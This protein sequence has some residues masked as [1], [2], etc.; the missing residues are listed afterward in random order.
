MTTLCCS[1]HQDVN[2]VTHLVYSA[3]LYTEKD[4]D[5]KLPAGASLANLRIVIVNS[6]E[7]NK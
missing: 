4:Y 3:I 1:E 2:T 6:L 7:H 5:N